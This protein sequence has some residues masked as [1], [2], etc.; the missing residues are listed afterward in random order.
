MHRRLVRYNNEADRGETAQPNLE[1]RGITQG[2]FD[3]SIF[4]AVKI[5]KLIAYATSALLPDLATDLF[6][7]RNIGRDI[8]VESFI[9]YLEAVRVDRMIEMCSE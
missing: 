4:L 7:L 5:C 2:I 6:E 3:R 8:I 9:Y 1:T